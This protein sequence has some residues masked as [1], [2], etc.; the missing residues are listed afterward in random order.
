[1][2]KGSFYHE[3][4][5]GHKGKIGPGDL[6]WMTAGRGIVHSEMP[7]S[8]E[9]DSLGFQLWVNLQAKNNMIEPVY[10]EF[11]ADKIPLVEHD[12]A[13]VKV[14]SGE[15]EKV[16]GPI[17]AKTPAYYFDVELHKN[18]HFDLEIPSGWNAF[19]FVF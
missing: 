4:F 7:A 17:V 14:I 11:K 1:M 12:A 3:D 19:I 15:W 10:Q 18:G 5:K 6:Q 8:S 13:R 2:I 9:E 16:K